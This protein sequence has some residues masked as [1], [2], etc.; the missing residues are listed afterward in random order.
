MERSDSNSDQT[1]TATALTSSFLSTVQAAASVISS[2]HTAMTHALCS[3][4]ILRKLIKNGAGAL[5]WSTIT[6]SVSTLSDHSS[7]TFTATTALVDELRTELAAVRASF[8]SKISFV[9]ACESFGKACAYPGMKLCV[10]YRSIFRIVLFDVLI[11][12]ILFDVL[13]ADTFI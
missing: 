13:I 5:T 4:L 7:S 2:N 11:A 10:Y 12:D 9:D 6:E 8:D 3:A 1:A